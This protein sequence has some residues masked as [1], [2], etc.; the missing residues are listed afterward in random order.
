MKR[1][2][3]HRNETKGPVVIRAET[4]TGVGGQGLHSG[5]VVQLLPMT[6]TLYALGGWYENAHREF[7][8]ITAG[9]VSGTLSVSLGSCNVV[10]TTCRACGG[11]QRYLAY[12]WT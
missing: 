6:N 8:T 9:I 4:M 10:S 1:S 5:A 3:W 7:G 2:R 11:K 12:A